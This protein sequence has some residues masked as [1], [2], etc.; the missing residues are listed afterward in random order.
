[1][2]KTGQPGGRDALENTRLQGDIHSKPPEVGNAKS[3]S[4]EANVAKHVVSGAPN[5]N[6]KRG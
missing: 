5:T 3:Q 4:M 1:M 6:R 2:A